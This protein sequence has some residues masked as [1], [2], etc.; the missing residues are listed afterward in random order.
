VSIFFRLDFSM[1]YTHSEPFGNTEGSH[2]RPRSRVFFMA[3][4][5]AGAGIGCMV[6]G[7]PFL[8][9][10]PTQQ[11]IFPPVSVA[12]GTSVSQ[13]PSVPRRGALALTTALGLL[14]P[15]APGHAVQGLTPGRIPGLGPV[16]EDGF[17]RYTRPEGK[18]GGH[19]VGWSEIPKYTFRLPA[20]FREMPVSI[21][22][23]GGTEIDARFKS[24]E[25]GDIA[26]VVAP[27]N[28]FRDVGFNA[29]IT[30][31]QVG[32]PERLV[33]GFAPEI[34]GDPIED[35]DVRSTEV[36]K[37]DGLVYY[38]FEVKPRTLVTMTATGNRMFLWVARATGRQWAKHAD[39]L[40]AA[41]TSFR[42]P[43]VL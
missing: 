4:F 31:E 16:E 3:C 19:G 21:A 17:M 9:I 23:L 39:D 5:L 18:S 32:P 29:R 6:S 28:R 10:S 37:R 42:V 1:M 38:Q 15:N 34:T 40:R 36:S 2:R 33:K 43:E 27:I 11:S 8:S 22:D 24:D 26:I 13:V 20:G 30:I 25:A 7:V 12:G 35:E 14:L 41:A